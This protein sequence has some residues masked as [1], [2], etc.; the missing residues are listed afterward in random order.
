MKAFVAL[1]GVVL[2][3]LGAL[4]ILM[5]ELLLNISRQ[6]ATP[7]GLWVTGIVRVAL[8]LAFLAVASR[9]RSRIGMTILGVIVVV[10]GVITPFVGAARAQ[11]WLD[12][13]SGQ[14]PLPLRVTGLVALALGAFIAY[15][16]APS[17]TDSDK[18]AR[19]SPRPLQGA[20]GSSG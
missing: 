8:G 7:E 12:W 14:G 20:A 2:A 3:V 5:P 18:R 13:W 17:D 10:G 11:G 16:A 9:S 19:K 6:A 15:A 4:G 1:V